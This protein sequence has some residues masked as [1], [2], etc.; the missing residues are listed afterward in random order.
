[1]KT[2]Q[3]T[4]GLSGQ[5]GS[6]GTL[7][8]TLRGS[9]DVVLRNEATGPGNLDISFNRANLP[10]QGLWRTVEATWDA[11]GTAVQST[12]P[13]EIEALGSI[14]FSKYNTPYESECSTATAPAFVITHWLRPQNG[15]YSCL[16]FPTTLSSAFMS[17]VFLN[18]TGIS[19]VKSYNAG[20]P[21]SCPLVS[22]AGM[23]AANTFFAVPI[24]DGRCLTPVTEGAVA[25]NPAPQ[26]PL[27]LPS[28]LP[29]PVPFNAG[30]FTCTDQ[31]VILNGNQTD[32]VRQVVD[33]CP[34]CNTDFRGTNGHID[35]YTSSRACAP[36]DPSVLDYGTLKAIRTR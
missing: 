6:S 33:L 32:S 16:F 20:S 12:R 23:T 31:I 19:Q 7:R 22:Q 17:Q 34:G 30:G 25:V 9:S 36:R 3:I 35:V 28:G 2:D 18:G 15:T 5:V 14:R 21:A 10:S 11:G 24:V 29:S 26:R 8:V 1:V 27:I 13:V 4:I